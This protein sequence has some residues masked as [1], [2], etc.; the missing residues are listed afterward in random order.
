MKQFRDAKGRFVRGA[1]G[2]GGGGSS[3][4][5]EAPD[6]LRSN[7][8][9][10]YVDALC[11]GEILGLVNGMKSVYIN[12]TPLE[13]ADGSQNF[14]GI[15]LQWR[16]GTLTQTAMDGFS[17]TEIENYVGTEVKK[18]Q[19]ITRALNNPTCKEVRVT[20]AVPGLTS[21]DSNGNING[22]SV[23]YQIAIQNNGGGFV[24]VKTD[25]ISGKT[26]SK[27]KRA[28]RL[29]LPGSGP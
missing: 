9:A 1:G 21:Y 24:T 5:A 27:Y 4:G 16:N 22:S 29:T 2:G 26:N 20:V 28:H 10:R 23:S 18:A 3:G 15:N 25:T 8:I 17:Q 6:S 13:N 12:G 7:Q 19:P 11:E 14:G